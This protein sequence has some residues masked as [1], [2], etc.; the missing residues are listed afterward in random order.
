MVYEDALYAL[1]TARNAGFA[2]A[3]VFE[4]HESRQ[5]EMKRLADLYLE[6]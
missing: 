4:P 3:A 1:T 6:W 2:T 5:D